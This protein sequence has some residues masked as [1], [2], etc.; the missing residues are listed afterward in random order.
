MTRALGLAIALCTGLAACGVGDDG[1]IPP[2]DDTNQ[3]V[4][5]TAL[6]TVSGTFTAAATLDPLGGCQP[7]GT[8]SFTVSVMD[9]GTCSAVP[10]KSS[11]VY[12]V[13]GVGHDETI[14]YQGASSGEDLQLQISDPG[15]GGCEGSFEHILA[16]GAT[17]FDQFLLKPRT[18]KP[19]EAVTT[20]AISGDGE[21]DLWKQH[22]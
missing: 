7:A 18:P 14:T 12:Q 10:A 3:N 16:N 15:T 8:W 17:N 20:L 13:V 2:G 19:T 11:Y 22:P 6:L 21:Y 4:L 5:C 9:Q 1:G